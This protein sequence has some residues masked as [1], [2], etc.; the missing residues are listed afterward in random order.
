MHSLIRS[1]L[2]TKRVSA[3]V[4]AAVPKCFQDNLLQAPI[5]SRSS[6]TE[7][8]S[9]TDNSTADV[10]PNQGFKGHDML[11]PFT[12]GWQAT[13]LNP[14]VIEKSEGFY[15]YDINGKK[16]L[17]ALASLWCTALGGSE[18]R[19]VDAATSQLNKLPFYHSFWN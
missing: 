12:A 3:L 5:W 16:Y 8:S 1:T 2:R 13:D 10:K 6:S 18:K 19:L 7:S 14:L 15:V 11:A 17:D 4:C 9:A